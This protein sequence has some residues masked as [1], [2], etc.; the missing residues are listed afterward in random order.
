MNPA[1]GPLLWIVIGAVAG[2]VASRIM[3]TD[4]SQGTLGNIVVGIIGAVVGGALTRWGFGD[5]PNNNGLLTSF[6]VALLGS[7]CVILALRVLGGRK[8]GL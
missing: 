6:G 4:S 5:N 2:W 3:N 7:C 8:A 1:Y